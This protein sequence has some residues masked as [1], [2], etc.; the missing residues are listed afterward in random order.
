M[1]SV[2]LHAQHLLMQAFR[3]PNAELPEARACV[4]YLL[5]LKSFARIQYPGTE[6]DQHS[7]DM[8]FGFLHARFLR[9]HTC[10]DPNADILLNIES[11]KDTVMS[12]CA[13]ATSIYLENRVDQAQPIDLSLIHISEPTRHSA[14]SRMPSSA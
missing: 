3:D 1:Y 6:L 13:A 7:A 5:R 9:V 14:I 8:C 11:W 10:L 12:A 4:T 2:L